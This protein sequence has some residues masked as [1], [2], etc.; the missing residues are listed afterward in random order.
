MGVL[1][2]DKLFVG[3]REPL[4]LPMATSLLLLLSDPD[5]SWPPLFVFAFAGLAGLSPRFLFLLL[6]SGARETSPRVKPALVAW[7]KAWK[8]CLSAEAVPLSLS[9]TQLV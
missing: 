7:I 9:S 2:T 3:V 6:A 8:V 5:A 1:D 4:S